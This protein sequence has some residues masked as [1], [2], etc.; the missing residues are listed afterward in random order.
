LIFIFYPLLI[1]LICSWTL[2][3]SSWYSIF[4]YLHVSVKISNI[5]K[6]VLVN[7]ALMIWLVLWCLTPL[8]TIFQL[9]G[10]SQFYWWRKPED[11]GENHWPVTSHWQTLSH[12]VVFNASLRQQRQVC[13]MIKKPKLIND[14]LTLEDIRCFFSLCLGFLIMFIKSKK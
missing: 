12:N 14:K 10:S 3:L 1:L 5:G 13:R 6:L 4:K 11:R 2:K 8:S 9:Y 7:V